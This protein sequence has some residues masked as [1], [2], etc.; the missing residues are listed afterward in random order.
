MKANVHY[1]EGSIITHPINGSK[2]KLM[3]L[4]GKGGYGQVWQAKV[5]SLG[6]LDKAAN[7]KYLN[8]RV[9]VK[10]SVKESKGKYLITEHF[11]LKKVQGLPG[12][13]NVIEDLSSF[14]DANHPYIVQELMKVSLRK[15]IKYEGKLSVQ[16]ALHLALCLLNTIEEIHSKG[17]IHQDIKPDNI[18]VSRVHVDPAQCST[19]YFIDFGGACSQTDSVDK[20]NTCKN[21]GTSTFMSIRQQ[22]Y[23]GHP[24]YRDDI[25]TIVYTIVACVRPDVMTWRNIDSDDGSFYYRQAME[26]QR[27]GIDHLYEVFGDAYVPFLLMLMEGREATPSKPNYDMIRKSFEIVMQNTA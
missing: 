4:L 25:E 3:K 9:A 18:M 7:K 8:K 11:I 15:F 19:F 2:L 22:L 10:L 23:G 21:V 5:I 27:F 26:K 24:V 12:I 16:D 1:T 17:V 20:V 6:K 13:V 14:S